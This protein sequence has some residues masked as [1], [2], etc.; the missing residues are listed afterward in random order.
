MKTRLQ[1]ISDL[2]NEA[3]MFEVIRTARQ[4]T[5]DYA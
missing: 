1:I 4:N 5:Q 2:L 3:G